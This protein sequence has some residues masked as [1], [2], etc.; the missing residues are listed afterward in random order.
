MANNLTAV[1]WLE[2]EIKKL[3]IKV[4]WGIQDSAIKILEQAKK[5]DY[6]QKKAAWKNGRQYEKEENN[7]LNFNHYYNTNYKNINFTND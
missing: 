1:E 6:E 7:Y 4:D 3:N 5:M 2:Q